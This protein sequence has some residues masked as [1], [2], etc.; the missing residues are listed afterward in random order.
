VTVGARQPWCNRLQW[1]SEI[2]HA[3]AV[4]LAAATGAVVGVAVADAGLFPALV[5]VVGRGLRHHC[6]RLRKS[7]GNP[8]AHSPAELIRSEVLTP[9]RQPL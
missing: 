4:P 5:A 6:R 2:C 1:R 7:P 9:S 8:G 3:I